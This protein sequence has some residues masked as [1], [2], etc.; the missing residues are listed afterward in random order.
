[1]VGRGITDERKRAQ[2]EA[3]ANGISGY[4]KA[5]APAAPIRPGEAKSE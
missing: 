3:L 2:R 5:T 4:L 1:M